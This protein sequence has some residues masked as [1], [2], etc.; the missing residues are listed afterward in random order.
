MAD[1][2]ST[3]NMR[4]NRA[5]Q[6]STPGLGPADAVSLP[7]W[8]EELLAGAQ[9]IEQSV[10]L[11]DLGELRVRE[12]ATMDALL[13][14]VEIPRARCWS[15]LELR[16]GTRQAYAFHRTIAGDS[17]HP[18]RIWN[19]IPGITEPMRGDLDRYR[20]FNLG[21][22]DAVWKWF[23]SGRQEFDRLPPATAVGHTG[24]DLTI[25]MLMFREPPIS[26]E[27]PRQRPAFRYSSLY[28]PKPPCFSRASIIEHSG[29]RSMLIAG[30][31]SILGERSTHRGRVRGQIL[32]TFSNLE[33][34]IG[35]VVEDGS[36]PLQRLTHTRAYSPDPTKDAVIHDEMHRRLNGRPFDIVRAD[37][38][39]PE[40][41]VE[42]EAIA[43]LAASPNSGV[44]GNASTR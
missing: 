1:L 19:F 34:L 7:S 41:L 12:R 22:Y 27:N 40:L 20:V 26:V 14:T 6:H 39:R 42:I 15:P 35:S 10:S 11:G 28:G 23:G 24:N 30:T 43:S 16:R 8:A 33:A 9:D 4:V 44:S 25:H 36:D 32:A 5:R 38:C 3:A 13:V 21:R 2:L 18:V 37:L 31:A 29:R 17:W